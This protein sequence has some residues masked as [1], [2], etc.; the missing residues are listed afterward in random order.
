VTFHELCRRLA[1]RVA[2]ETDLLRV[3]EPVIAASIEAGMREFANHCP[4]SLLEFAEI[5]AMEMEPCMFCGNFVDPE[6]LDSAARDAEGEY[7]CAAC[8]VE[9]VQP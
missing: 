2:L 4:S 3:P 6:K 5:E 7:V 9:A 1:R 8:A